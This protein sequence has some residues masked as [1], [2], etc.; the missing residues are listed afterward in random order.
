MTIPVFTQAI[1]QTYYDGAMTGLGVMEDRREFLFDC[2]WN[3]DDFE[4]RV[5]LLS[6]LPQGAYAKV[7]DML[8]AY[9]VVDRPI[10]YALA[11]PSVRAQTP[12][13]FD[14]WLDDVLSAPG[15]PE[16]LVLA[17]SSFPHHYLSIEPVEKTYTAEQIEARAGELGESLRRG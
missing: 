16:Y 15:D 5:F 17:Q 3:S 10:W 8:S 14:K 9:E 2:S 6:P 13:E 12:R 4:I 1:V 7:V 11:N